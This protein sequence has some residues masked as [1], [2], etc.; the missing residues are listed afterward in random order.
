MGWGGVGWWGG[1]GLETFL[2][3][4]NRGVGIMR[5]GG[6]GGGGKNDAKLFWC[7]FN[8]GRTKCCHTLKAHKFSLL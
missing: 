7:Q 4:N 2:K 8:K 1:E 6:R 5:D 3:I